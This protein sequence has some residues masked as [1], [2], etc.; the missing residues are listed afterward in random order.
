MHASAA[1][2][3]IAASGGRPGHV[4]TVSAPATAPTPSAAIR[5][6]NPSGPSPRT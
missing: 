1:V 2:A 4:P 3:N 5:Y 6:P